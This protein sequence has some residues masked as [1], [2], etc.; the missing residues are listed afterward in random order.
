M[1]LF[2][3]ILLGILQGLTEFLPISSTAH[4]TIAGKWMGLIDPSHPEQWTAFIAVIQMGTLLAVFVY[5]FRDVLEITASF[6]VENVVSRTRIKH[7]SHQARLGWFVIIGSVPIAIIGL[8]FKKIIEGHLTKS[9]TVIAITLI[10]L[11][12]LLALSEMTGRFRKDT[13]RMSFLDAIL[14]GFAQSLALIPGASR[15]GTTITAGLFLGMTRES[16]ARFSFLLSMPAV[17]ASG[18]LEFRESLGFMG[19]QDM[20]VLLAATLAAAVSGY[21][22]I[23]FLIRFLKTHTTYVFVSYRLVLGAFILILGKYFNLV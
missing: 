7:Q 16:A 18:L 21:A 11:A 1:G 10:V 23:A 6:V 9:L 4:L 20:L 12:M 17:F 2:E 5:F 8:T 14:I 3:G 15:S 19:S 22:A 13:R